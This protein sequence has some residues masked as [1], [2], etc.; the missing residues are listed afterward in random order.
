VLDLHL[1]ARP[2]SVR[3]VVTGAGELRARLATSGSIH[4]YAT[5]RLQNR[6]AFLLLSLL[7]LLFCV[8]N[9]YGGE[10]NLRAIT[11][12]PGLCSFTACFAA[13]FLG[14]GAFGLIAD[15][16]CGG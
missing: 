9:V 7:V 12:M 4:D 15:W 1:G 8:R 13:F 11:N 5:Q 10:E 14:F 16:I 2:L 6:V 3:S